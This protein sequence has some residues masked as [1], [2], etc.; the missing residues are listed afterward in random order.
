MLSVFLIN[1]CI[2]RVLHI[3][4]ILS[5]QLTSRIESTKFVWFLEEVNLM[6]KN[7]H[8]DWSQVLVKSSNIKPADR[9]RSDSAKI[10]RRHLRAVILGPVTLY[11]TSSRDKFWFPFWYR[12][13]FTP[14]H[15]EGG[16]ILK[17]KTCAHVSVFRLPLALPSPW[18][19]ICP[20]RDKFCLRQLDLLEASRRHS[21]L[22]LHSGGI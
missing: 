16:G 19:K 2:P 12:T 8:C 5:R 17:P 22:A 7:I 6:W 9:L 10:H 21:S 20:L 1:A 18:Q 13:H 15:R 11:W 4:V 14:I 3:W